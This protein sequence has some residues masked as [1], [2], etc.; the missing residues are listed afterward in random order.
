MT[1]DIV[2]LNSQNLDQSGPK[3]LTSLEV[4]GL[5]LIM[6]IGEWSCLSPQA[7]KTTKE[8]VMGTKLTGGQ[9]DELDGKLFELKRQ[10]RQP[11]G[12]PFDPEKLSVF[13]QRAVEGRFEENRWQ[14]NSRGEICLTLRPT[15]G[16]IGEQWLHYFEDRNYSLDDRAR[17]LLTHSPIGVT[18]GKIYDVRI[19]PCTKE[20]VS[21][22]TAVCRARERGLNKLIME[23]ACVFR[24][25]YTD[26]EIKAMGFRKVLVV[27]EPVDQHLL[28]VHLGEAL[29]GQY[30]PGGY[31]L[32]ESIGLAFSAT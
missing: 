21:V 27:H 29:F 31:L 11:G 10:M 1:T 7:D 16:W 18:T 8:I 6:S 12:Y 30:V 2:L 20:C 22:Q 25:S 9:Y 23:A 19:I 13:L 14:I 15:E 28:E 24:A 5:G 4:F 26:L 3:T 17:Y 32:N